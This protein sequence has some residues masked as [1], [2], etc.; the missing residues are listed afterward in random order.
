MF[1]K[2]ITSIV[3]GLAITY[4]VAVHSQT[5]PIEPNPILTPGAV[6][7]NATK[8]KVC[9]P[10][11]T[12]TVRNVPDS[13]KRQVFE[14]YH[15]DPHSDKFEVDHLVSLELGGSNDV[16]NLWPQ[17]YTTQPFNAHVKDKIENELHRR[18]CDGRITLQEA[19]QQIAIDWIGSYCTVYVD[20]VAECEQHKKEKANNGN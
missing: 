13:I 16:K 20:K 3:L 19:Q 10:G 5:L 17:S 7:P 18:I 8:D 2:T 11:Y 15:I 12:S 4:G 6:D 14:R 1:N 9:T